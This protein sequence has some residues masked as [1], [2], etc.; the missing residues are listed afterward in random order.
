VF[1]RNV[2]NI[3]YFPLAWITGWWV[4]PYCPT[5]ESYQVKHLQ[6][7]A[8]LNELSHSYEVAMSGSQTSKTPIRSLATLIHAH[9]IIYDDTSG[10]EMAN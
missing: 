3:T 1:E 7:K 5:L 8:L 6:A 2:G 4:T 10:S 9:K